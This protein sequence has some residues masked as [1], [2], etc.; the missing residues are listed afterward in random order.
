MTP[1][2][3]ARR[4]AP[5]ITR[6]GAAFGDDPAFAAAAARFGGD[7]WPLYFAARAGVLGPVDADVV[8]AVCGFFAPAFVRAAWE[9]VPPGELAE[10][11][12]L[13][14]ELCAAWA[15]QHLPDDDRLA[16][17]TAA[18]VAAAD[19][20]GRPLFAAWRALPDHHHD[21]AARIGLNLLRLREHRG[22]SHLIAVVAG[23]GTP[24]DAVLAAGGHRKAIAN[25][26]QPPFP[27]ATPNTGPDMRPDPDLERRTDLL[28]AAPFA[29]LRE[30]DRD[31][32]AE[33]L[34]AVLRTFRSPTS[35]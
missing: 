34:E 19:A 20:A 14:V 4:A 22:G 8:A 29:G 23:G 35:G 11:V 9:R 13:D 5:A 15:R 17:L 25:G 7:R 33:R 32:L 28:A 30:D 21:A 27:K 1:E 26:W 18:A 10:L 16:E 12:A 6:L 3:A 31:E 2:E 24:L